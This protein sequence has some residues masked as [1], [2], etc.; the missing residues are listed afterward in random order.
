MNLSKLWEIVENRWAWCATV[1]EITKSQTW[2]CDWIT[3][4][5]L[6]HCFSFFF[7]CKLI[8]LNQDSNKIPISKTSLL[9]GAVNIFFLSVLPSLSLP[10]S[11][12]YLPSPFTVG[13]VLDI[14]EVSGTQRWLEY[15][16][17]ILN[18]G[19]W[20]PIWLSSY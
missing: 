9:V 8:W 10:L 18:S 16:S 14:W 4:V 3:T 17:M 5:F 20:L 1:L 6:R 7:F 13:Q 19:I 11:L 2:H 15:Q 12:A